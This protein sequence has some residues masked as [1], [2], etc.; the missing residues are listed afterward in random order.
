MSRSILDD[1]GARLG[2]DL[3]RGKLDGHKVQTADPLDAEKA[4]SNAVSSSSP[5]SSFYELVTF[6]QLAT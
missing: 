4:G 6:S 5:S 1:L 3:K 2:G